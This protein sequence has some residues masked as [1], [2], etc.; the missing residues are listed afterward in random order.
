M[1]KKIYLVDYNGDLI[2]EDVVA[3]TEY[4]WTYSFDLS[5]GTPHI[6]ATPKLSGL[7]YWSAT[8]AEAIERGLTAQRGRKE[9]LVRNLRKLDKTI[10]KVEKLAEKYK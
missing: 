9:R 10:V 4:H 3:E 1:N 8:P 7:D 5:D 2:E 6:V